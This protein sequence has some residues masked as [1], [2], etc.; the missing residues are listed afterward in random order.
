MGGGSPPGA[1]LVG[2]PKVFT[3]SETRKQ[4]QDKLFNSGTCRGIQRPFVTR[5]PHIVVLRVK[6]FYRFG[7]VLILSAKQ[8]DFILST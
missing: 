1:E 3:V 7:R 5:T 8:A 6:T 4:H 2:V